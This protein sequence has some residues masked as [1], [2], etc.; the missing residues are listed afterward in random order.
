MLEQHF[1]AKYV[2]DGNRVRENT[3]AVV[4]QFSTCSLMQRKLTPKVHN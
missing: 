2:A 1:G 4:F 3:A